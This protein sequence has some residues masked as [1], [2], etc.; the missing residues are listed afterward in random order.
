MVKELFVP[1]FVIGILATMLLPM[2]PGVMDFLLVGN[3][4]F[5]LVLL[6]ITLYI[7]EPVRLSALPS[8][9]LLATMYRLALN[10]STTRLILGSGDAGQVVEAFGAVVVQGN[11]VV[12]AVVFLVITLV[13]FIVIAKGSERVAEVAARFTL[14]AMPGK[15]MSIDADVRA[16]L[17]DF[18]GA[19][20]KR[21]ELQTESRFYG[22]LDGAMKFIKGDAIAGIVITIVNIIGG[23][24][25]GLGMEGLP[26]DV[27]LHKYSI[28]TVGDGLLSQIPSLLNSLAAGMVVT[29]VTRDDGKSLAADLLTQLTQEKRVRGIIATLSLV[30]AV[31]PGMPALPFVC[32]CGALLMSILLEPRAKEDPKAGEIMRFKPKTPALLHVEVGPELGGALYAS[33]KLTARI[34]LLRQSVYERQGLV[35]LQ[36]GFSVERS[37]GK[38]FRVHF[39]GIPVGRVIDT[40]G[41]LAAME[42]LAESLMTLV[43]RRAAECVDDI[44]TRRLLDHLEEEAPE[45]VAHVVPNVATVTQLSELLKQLVGEGISIRHFDVIVQAVAEFGPKVGNERQ[46]LE[47]V[48]IALRRVISARLADAEGVMRA[49]TLDPIMDLSFAKV[50]RERG[51]LDLDYTRQIA[52]FI[53]GQGSDHRV[54]LVSRGARRLLRECLKGQ[55]LTIAVVAHDEISEDIQVEIAGHIA[56]LD[57]ESQE[58]AIES[59]AA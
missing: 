47:E 13:Q 18:S 35:L 9:L 1:L 10:I 16:G 52:E 30:L 27:A 45:L 44:L 57:G 15:Q 8:I 19:R 5:A 21:Q 56:F 2:P 36:P 49:Y 41:T 37:L 40:D 7:P 32:V 31:L 58:R 26:V 54:L 48:R 3:L 28:L 38:G 25:I 4:L 33:G 42:I 12:G 46:L 55:G 24:A 51:A 39:R 6:L 20:T 53:R 23:L 22:A 50:E 59:L 17:L 43:E 34:E 29:R 11:L 14:D